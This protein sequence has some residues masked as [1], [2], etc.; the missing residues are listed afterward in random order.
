L[1]PKDLPC[2]QGGVKRGQRYRAVGIVGIVVGAIFFAFGGCSDQ[3]EGERCQ[4]LNGN[5]DC[6]NGLVCVCATPLNCINTSYGF[7]NPPYNTSDRCCPSERALATTP[8]CVAGVGP[9][10]GDA[11]VPI[12]EAGP[13]AAAD[14][15]A[16]ADAQVASDASDAD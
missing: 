5:D 3:G 15:A 1:Q 8:Q 6:Q 10:T 2:H 11:N 14:A 9:S 12:Q 7:V 16:D 13:E 4:T